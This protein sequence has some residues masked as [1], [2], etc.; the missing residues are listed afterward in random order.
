MSNKDITPKSEKI[1]AICGSLRQKSFTRF[2]LNIALKGAEELKAQTYLV[3]LRDYNLPFYDENEDYP[4][5]VFRLRRNVSE[6]QGIILGSPE[7]HGGYTGI[8]KNALDLMGFREFQSKIV[9]LIG[10]AGG[11]AGAIN[12]VNGLRIVCRNLRSWVL[13][14]QVSIP[15]AKNE[16]DD[17]GHPFNSNLEERLK[18]VGR[19]VTKFSFLHNSEQIKEFLQLWEQE[20]QNSGGE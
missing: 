20:P 13:P 1:V 17:Q 3:D 14:L 11:A 15:N 5:D 18:E 7:F 19:Q 9:G 4:E 8:L 2:A 16:F 6:A 12:T 10:I